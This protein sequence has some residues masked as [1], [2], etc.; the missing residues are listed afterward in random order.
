VLLPNNPS[1]MLSSSVL[2][3]NRG[4]FARPSLPWS[5]D[6]LRSEGMAVSCSSQSS[7]SSSELPGLS[8]SL[9]AEMPFPLALRCWRDEER[10]RDS[11]R[12]LD[13]EATTGEVL[14][15]GG[16]RLKSSERVWTRVRGCGG[17]FFLSGMDSGIRRRMQ[18]S[19]ST[20]W[21]ESGTA[22]SV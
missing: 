7:N 15:F 17:G 10:V 21:H 22:A 9:S 18:A 12:E 3:P 5:I 2:R 8:G 14:L 4:A 20:E 11:W 13:P 1:S 6:G 19:D 16:S